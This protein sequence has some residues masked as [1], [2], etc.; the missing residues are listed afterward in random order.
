MKSRNAIPRK[1]THCNA[2][3]SN[4][5]TTSAR[6]KAPNRKAPARRSA[7]FLPNTNACRTKRSR[8]SAGRFFNSATRSVISD[9]VLR[10]IQRDID[11]AEARLQA[12]SFFSILLKNI[13]LRKT[14]KKKKIK[15]KTNP[16]FYISSE[17][18][19]REP[20]R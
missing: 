13:I 9:E 10:R 6:W 7:F 15:T 3:A 1:P 8:W 18:S 14:Q 4:T 16:L 2:C 19:S 20:F 12:S 5:K 17:K 11:L